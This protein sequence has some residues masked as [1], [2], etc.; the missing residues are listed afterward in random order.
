MDKVKD[1]KKILIKTDKVEV[2]AELL[3]EENNK[4]VEA[5]WEGLPFK[6]RAN[7]WGDE[8]YFSI[9]V[10][11]SPEKTKVVVKKG[12]LAYW[13]PGRALCIFFGPTPASVG[14]E[15]RAASPVGVFGR[16]LEGMERLGE[17]EDGDEI[18][19]KRIE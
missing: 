7:R 12:T 4:L 11:A 19:V 18:V 8:I 17:I 1:M 6:A 5:I 14:D 10:T 15:I 3:S 9:P 2:V 16:V 13:P